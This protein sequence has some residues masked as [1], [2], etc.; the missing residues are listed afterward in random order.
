M[1]IQNWQI[2]IIQIDIWNFSCFQSE[3]GGLV[4]HRLFMRQIGPRLGGVRQF[5][6][7]LFTA[8]FLVVTNNH[9]PF[10][11][12]VLKKTCTNLHT[13]IWFYTSYQRNYRSNDKTMTNQFRS[14]RQMVRFGSLTNQTH[15]ACW[16]TITTHFL[17]AALPNTN[18]AIDKQYFRFQSLNKIILTSHVK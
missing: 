3:V 15:M 1:C 8:C 6:F 13:N 17:H 4:R 5:D 12:H 2:I 14:P 10:A 18:A 11:C 7:F 16:R 9:I